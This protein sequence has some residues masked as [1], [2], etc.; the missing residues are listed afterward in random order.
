MSSQETSAQAPCSGFTNF[1]KL[2][3]NIKSTLDS[4]KV[5]SLVLGICV[6]I[7]S[8]TVVTFYLDSANRQMALFNSKTNDDS[9]DVKL[10][11]LSISNPQYSPMCG[12][13]SCSEDT[14]TAFLNNLCTT[15]DIKACGIKYTC[16]K[17]D[18][19]FLYISDRNNNPVGG[20]L[21]FVA[22]PKPNDTLIIGDSIQASA[23]PH[24]D[25]I[26]IT[27]YFRK[28]VRPS[29]YVSYD[30]VLSHK[31]FGYNIQRTYWLK[32]HID[33]PLYNIKISIRGTILDTVRLSFMTSDCNEDSIL[34]NL[35][36]AV[37]SVSPSSKIINPSVLDTGWYH[38]TVSVHTK[39]DTFLIPAN[40]GGGCLNGIDSNGWPRLEEPFEVAIEADTPIVLPLTY[41][42]L[43]YNNKKLYWEAALDENIMS[44]DIIQ[45]LNNSTK[46]EVI[47]ASIPKENKTHYTFE[48]ENINHEKKYYK[49]V[50][51]GM[52]GH[53]VSSNYIGPVSS[54]NTHWNFNSNTNML[55][56]SVPLTSPLYIFDATGRQLKPIQ[57]DLYTLD[58][59]TY[60]S[61]IYF[62]YFNELEK[63]KLNIIRR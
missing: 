45:S 56:S 3:F 21:K 18:L 17:T 48:L 7:D 58:F 54:E 30:S 25:T 11:C 40:Y 32:F 29:R 47:I 57:S 34:Y 52:F 26:N 37:F 1:Q 36:T 28:L 61:G 60:N 46:N 14:G 15:C 19:Y 2:N 9:P 53:Q 6:R 24:A 20:W 41:I 63:I 23:C 39:I 42:N 4:V 35:D 31:G 33:S 13:P 50:A 49:I 55:T 8:G 27:G 5:D 16:P 44:F 22:E 43:T 51:N 62:I 59:S 10:S 38:M 12:S